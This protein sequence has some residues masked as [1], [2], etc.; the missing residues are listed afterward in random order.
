MRLE[1][2]ALFYPKWGPLSKM[3]YFYG[4]AAIESGSGSC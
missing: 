3:C 1:K 2:H 4:S